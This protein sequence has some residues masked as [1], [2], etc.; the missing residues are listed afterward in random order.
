MTIPLPDGPR[1][2]ISHGDVSTM[3][4]LLGI[5]SSL[6]G[7]NSKHIEENVVGKT[8]QWI[9]KMR[10]AH[11][12]VHLGWLAYRFKLWVGIR[13][14]IATY[15]VPL[16]VAQR[17]LCIEDSHCFSFLGNN[18]N[19]KKGMEDD[20]QSFWRHQLV[21]LCGG[22]DDWH[23]QY[24]HS[25]HYVA[26]TTLAKK[27]SASLEAHQLKIGCIGNPLEGNFDEL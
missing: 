24:V 18:R 12:P 2:P 27:L 25:Q 9:N 3:E 5:W 13:Y 6:N 4:K 16:A 7:K 11:L 26:G 8:N 1:A 23:D 17:L 10:N 20:A 21:Q 15:S 22:T 14:G 19:V